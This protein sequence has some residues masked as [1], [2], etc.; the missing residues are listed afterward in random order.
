MSVTVSRKWAEASGEIGMWKRTRTGHTDGQRCGG[1]VEGDSV[2]GGGAGGGDEVPEQEVVDHPRFA[3]QRG[4]D[5]GVGQALRIVLALIAERVVLACDHERGWKSCE[6]LGEQR[7]HAWIGPDG[8]V[9]YPLDVE[10][11]D[12]GNLETVT[13]AFAAGHGCSGARR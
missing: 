10:P 2:S 5:A 11:F 12:V 9:G 13:V 3:S 8:A 7:A 6:V 4:G 1:D